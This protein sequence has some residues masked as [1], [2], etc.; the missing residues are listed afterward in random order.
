MYNY[1][2]PSKL[3]N[4]S[5]GIVKLIDTNND[6]NIIFESKILKHRYF[7][8]DS[9]I[10][11]ANV[12]INEFILQQGGNDNHTKFDKKYLDDIGIENIEVVSSHKDV[13]CVFKH[14]HEKTPYGMS[15]K[16]IDKV[17][18]LHNEV[19]ITRV[20]NGPQDYCL[21]TTRLF[22]NEKIIVIKINGANGKKKL[23]ITNY[24]VQE[25]IDHVAWINNLDSTDDV[26]LLLFGPICYIMC[27]AACIR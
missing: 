2:N 4:S 14:E 16:F 22:E 24:S 18:K 1:H 23:L 25:Y 19:N 13:D 20:S 10:I 7:N 6:N 27:V 9:I 21:T 11:G 3:N 12:F 8:R 5:E 17:K 26:L 15:K